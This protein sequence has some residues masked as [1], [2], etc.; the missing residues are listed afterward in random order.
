M[1]GVYDDMT[2]GGGTERPGCVQ[3]NA[4]DDG[5]VG[6][7]KGGMRNTCGIVLR[8]CP[9]KMRVCRLKAAKW[10]W[11]KGSGSIKPSSPSQLSPKRNLG[12]RAA[13]SFR[14]DPGYEGEVGAQ[15]GGVR[16]TCGIVLIFSPGKM[17]VCRLK[18]AKWKR[19]KGSGLLKLSSA[20][21]LSPKRNLG[22]RTAL[23]LRVDSG[24]EGQVGAQKGGMCN[25]C[26]IPP[27]IQNSECLSPSA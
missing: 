4:G 6:V 5:E 19:R 23:S 15:K 26:G 10:K 8:F 1:T 3:P 7:Q 13:L 27:I 18:A 20:S 17:R 9:S 12:T 22:I 2:N 24:D 16:N 11:G 14:V 25:T 21:Q